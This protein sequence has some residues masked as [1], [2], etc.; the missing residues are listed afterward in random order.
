MARSPRPQ[1]AKRWIK[2]KNRSHTATGFCLSAM[3]PLF[4]GFRFAGM[5]GIV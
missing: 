2:G 4:S 3:L 5:T 1:D